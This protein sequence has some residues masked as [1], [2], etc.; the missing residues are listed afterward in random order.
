MQAVDRGARPREE[1]G[2]GYAGR[3][4]R[5]IQEMIDVTGGQ[6][7]ALI[8]VLQQTQGLIGYLPATVIKTISRDLKIPLS[9]VYGIVSFY[10]FFTMVPKGKFVIQICMG[11][12]CYVKGGQRILD[13]LKKDWGLE[14]GEI[15]P[16]GRFSLE[17]VRCLGCCGLSPV[18]AIGEDV[19][20]KVKPS[21]LND[22]L[23]SYR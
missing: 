5:Q 6:A 2:M 13:T 17:T 12:S 9:E 11:T 21:K 4:F 7:G 14:P 10:H 20:R 18:V 16:D 22:I 3:T 23:I 8:R 15:T 19:H 1:G